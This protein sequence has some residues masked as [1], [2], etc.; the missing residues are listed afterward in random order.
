MAW[1]RTRSDLRQPGVFGS[2][3]A[4]PKEHKKTARKALSKQN[5]QQEKASRKDAKRRKDA[6]GE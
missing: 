3:G 6:K 1:L 4:K 5:K 2:F